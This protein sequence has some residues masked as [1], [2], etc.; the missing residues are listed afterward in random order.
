VWFKV[1]KISITSNRRFLVWM[2]VVLDFKNKSSAVYRNVFNLAHK[3][4]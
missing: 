1:S 3:A 4:L 2:E